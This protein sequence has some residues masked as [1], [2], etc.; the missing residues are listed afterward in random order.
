EYLATHNL[1]ASRLKLGEWLAET[2]G[3]AVI[4]ERRASER[5]L[6]KSAVSSSS[7]PPPRS[8]RSSSARP[9]SGSEAARANEKS[10]P[11]V[12]DPSSSSVLPV[13]ARLLKPAPI[14]RELALG[15]SFIQTMMIEVSQEESLPLFGGSGIPLGTPKPPP[16]PEQ[17]HDEQHQKKM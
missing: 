8:S 4:E 17:D 11:C 16:S 14:P 7:I 5:R 1:L 10:A 2:F 15:A 3:T 13:G 12:A 6:P 9:G